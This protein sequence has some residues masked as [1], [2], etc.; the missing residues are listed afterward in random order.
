[1]KNRVFFSPNTV[2]VEDGY[3]DD[4]EYEEA[5]GILEGDDYIDLFAMSL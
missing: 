1:M 4:D 3:V 2:E 5:D